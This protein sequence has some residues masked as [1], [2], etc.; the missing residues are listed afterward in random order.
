[1]KYSV[2]SAWIILIIFL[3]LQQSCLKPYINKSEEQSLILMDIYPLNIIDPSGLSKSYLDEHFFTV[4]DKSGNIYHITSFG[5][6]VEIIELGG[7]D[8]E[9]IEYLENDSVLYVL[10]EKLKIVI[11]LKFDGTILDTFQLNIPNL[12]LNHGPEGIAYNPLKE[13]FYIVNEKNPA[14]LYTYD[15]MFNPI[16]ENQLSFASDYS[17]LDYDAE[18]NHLWILSHESKLLARCNIQGVPD[19][20]YKT[21]IPKG[22]G[23]VVDYQRQLVYIVCDS[24]SALY[25]LE[26]P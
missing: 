1:M 12:F 10:E 14:I 4:C 13:H 5:E 24:T 25:V 8:L 23:V 6:I 15:K 17:S 9:G 21:G 11:S 2:T 3:W 22:E 16:S 7:D 19:K 26:F 18:R 20:T